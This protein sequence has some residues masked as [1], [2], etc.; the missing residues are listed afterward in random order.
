MRSI[1]HHLRELPSSLSI[2]GQRCPRLHILKFG[3]DRCIRHHE[4]KSCLRVGKLSSLIL[5][6]QVMLTGKESGNGGAGLS[7]QHHRQAF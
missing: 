3:V 5:I 4:Y 7:I 2:R 6:S 1:I